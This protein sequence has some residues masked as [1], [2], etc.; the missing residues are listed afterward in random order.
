MTLDS[1]V[2]PTM[3]TPLDGW[4]TRQQTFDAVL[5]ACRSIET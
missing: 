5:H 2:P 4:R 3:I 1:V